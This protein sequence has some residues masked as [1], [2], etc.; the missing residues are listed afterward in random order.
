MQWDE[1]RFHIRQ[2][3]TDDQKLIR[4]AFDLGK[5]AH[6]DQKRQ[7]GEPYFTH[8]IAVAQILANM[9]A[10]P[11]TVIAALLHDTVEDTP[12]KLEE[13]IRQFSPTVGALIDGVTK[14]SEEDFEERTNLNKQIET[15]RKMFNLMQ[16]DVRIMVIKLADRLHNMQTISFRP[17]EKQVAVAN[18]TMDV[19]V[20][21]AD[22][23]CMRDVRDELEGMCLAILDPMKYGRMTDAL[24]KNEEKS[25]S[26]LED[27]KVG[28]S[29]LSSQN[30]FDIHYERKSWESL[31]QQLDGLEQSGQSSTI[32]FAMLC[33]DIDGC[34]NVL[35]HLH[36]LWLRESRTFEDFINTPIIN[37]YKAIH[38]TIILEN[39]IR[40]RCKI[41]TQ[42]MEDYAHRG[43]TTVCFDQQQ[44]GVLEYLP[45]T[46]RISPLSKDTERQSQE[47][48]E[49]L[50]S[51]I[52]GESIFVYGDAD[53]TQLLPKGSTALDAVFYL[54]GDR[55][56][57]TKEIFINGKQVPFYEEVPYAGTIHAIFQKTS[58]MHLGWLQYSRTGIG[59]A[60][61]RKG[62]AKQDPA[63]KLSIGQKLL[64]DYFSSHNRGFI[65][66]LDKNYIERSLKENDYPHLEELYMRIAE[67]R[68]QPQQVEDVLYGKN[69]RKESDSDAHSYTLSL[70][71]ANVSKT[72]IRDALQPYTVKNFRLTSK[73]GSSEI[74]K[75]TLLLTDHDYD[76]LTSTL[77]HIVNGPYE[78]RRNSSVY[79]ASFYSLALFALWGLD[80]AV[81]HILLHQPGIGS[82]D[83]TIIRFVSQT[84]LSGIFLLWMRSR[85]PLPQARLSLT[86]PSLWLSVVFLFC[87]A[88]SSYGALRGT[89]PSY[90]SIPMT[91]AGL[92]LTTIVN[93]KRKWTLIAT[94]LLVIAGI[95]LLIGFTPDWNGRFITDTLL[96]VVA[97]TGFSLISERY[98][99]Q[100]KVSL[101]AAQY[102]FLLSAFC[103][104]LSLTL[105]P[106]A[107][108]G[109]ISLHNFLSIIL[110]SVFISGLPYYIY[111]YLLSHKEID[112][113]LRYS[114]LI[115][116]ATVLSEVAFIHIPH[117][118]VWPAAILVIAGAFLP[119]M[120][121][122]KKRA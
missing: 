88:L 43:I 48:W 115:I 34:Y 33:E 107:T 97:F 95:G 104:L 22:R 99:R 122:R 47:F 103:T 5:E 84:L 20:K 111:Y 58:D 28:L 13:I 118:V 53:Q 11:E 25:K 110:F 29:G 49:S 106:V 82:V 42:E 24:K 66:E 27:I 31:E 52:L 6:K 50:Q 87:V 60:L 26:I 67:G 64:Q 54:Y 113:V 105:L 71:M 36:R 101:R 12:L 1:F 79:K 65:S 96:A 90:Y 63:V 3:S 69:K 76:T 17:Q 93:R 61:I 8:P 77:D 81:A 40:V 108:L 120:T 78:I 30:P 55:G 9:G 32:N 98:K 92:I 18:E 19:Y 44:R 86:N 72:S 74:Y 116:P 75:L 121:W 57:R 21:I 70:N 80:P 10:D 56:L 38:T 15:L 68:V 112:F 41:R 14:L 119:L 117:P 4:Q 16:Q 59:T 2:H 85:Q 109:D 51:D 73:E 91:S 45:W 94:W 102:F 35:G 100:E 23:L 89:A 83:L 37:G 46:S 39:G 114:F 7:S 62:L